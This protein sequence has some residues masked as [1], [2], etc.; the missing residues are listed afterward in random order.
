MEISVPVTGDDRLFLRDVLRLSYRGTS[1]SASTSTTDSSRTPTFPLV[2]I[3]ASSLTPPSLREYTA[4]GDCLA[5]PLACS[6]WW[7]SADRYTAARGT[8]DS[9]RRFS[10]IGPDYR[11]NRSRLRVTVVICAFVVSHIE[12]AD[13]SNRI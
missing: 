9:A 1:R 7:V 12:I 3:S 11:S 6:P 5:Y 2:A 4:I 13:L 10:S 8:R